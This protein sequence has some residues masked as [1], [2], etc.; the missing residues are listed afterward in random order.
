RALEMARLGVPPAGGTAVY[1]NDPLARGRALYRDRCAGCH[2]LDGAGERKGP[3]LDGWSSRAWLRAFLTDPDG[4][5]FFRATRVHG[6]K[7]VKAAG[8]DLD[9][10]VEWVYALG[11]DGDAELA[12]RGRLVFDHSGCDDC[13]ETDGRTAGVGGAPNLGGHASAEW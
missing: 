13:H 9:A 10:L 5:R 6:M 2:V 4:A 3:D 11:G 12:A 1:E 7:P 8:A